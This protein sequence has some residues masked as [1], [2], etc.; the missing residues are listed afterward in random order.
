MKLRIALARLPVVTEI[1]NLC[2]GR[3]GQKRCRRYPSP[4]Y[5]ATALPDG[6]E[7]HLPSGT[8]ARRIQGRAR[9]RCSSP[10]RSPC[11]VAISARFAGLPAQVSLSRLMTRPLNSGRPKNM[12]KS[13]PWH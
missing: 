4:S 1:G 13:S 7:D 8:S 11:S 3:V 2:S 12:G 5:R 6:G 10:L 9:G